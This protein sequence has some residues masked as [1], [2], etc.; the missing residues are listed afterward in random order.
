MAYELDLLATLKI[1]PVFHVDQLSRYQGNEVNR[2][3]PPPPEPVMVDGEEEY[4]VDR[5]LDS[6]YFRQ[7]LQY[8]VHWK[9]Y[10][11]GE[12]SWEPAKNITNTQELIEEFYRKN[13]S[14][15]ACISAV[16]FTQLP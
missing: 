10:R 7:Q 6:R 16:L 14:A 15:L 11:E 8:L 2:Q 1:H 5:I 9:G 13:P 3:R 4:E 12:D